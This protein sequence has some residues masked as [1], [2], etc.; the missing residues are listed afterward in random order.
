MTIFGSLEHC[1]VIPKY[2]FFSFWDTSVKGDS[3]L[4]ITHGFI[5]KSLKLPMQ[6]IQKAEMMRRLFFNLIN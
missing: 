6:E 1:T 4:I 3:K 2:G 5:K